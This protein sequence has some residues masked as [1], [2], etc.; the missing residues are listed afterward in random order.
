MTIGPAAG[1]YK[2]QRSFPVFAGDD[3]EKQEDGRSGFPC[4][5]RKVGSPVSFL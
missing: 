4:L 3:G 1:I 5:A 2:T